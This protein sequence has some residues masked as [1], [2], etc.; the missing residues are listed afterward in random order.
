MN[1]SNKREFTD[2]EKEFLV[3]LLENSPSDFQR[4][5][6]ICQNFLVI[7]AASL[8]GLVL[9]WVVLI[10]LVNFVVAFDYGFKSDHSSKILIF[11]SLI[12]GLYSLFSTIK[13]AKNWTDHRPALRSDVEGGLV[14]DNTYEVSEVKRFQEQEHGG[15]I[16]FLRMNDN[17]VLTLYDYESVELQMEGNNPLQSNFKPCNKLR[18]VEAPKTGYFISQEF[19]G[20]ELLLSEPIDLLSSPDKW[21]EGESWCNIPWNELESR[22]ST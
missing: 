4:L 17:K 6:E 8:L 12:T 9:V 18:I 13:W 2:D 14:V 22:L 3:N 7:W 19:S 21:P 15:L 16:Y 5:K 20:E 1:S 10:W 11:L